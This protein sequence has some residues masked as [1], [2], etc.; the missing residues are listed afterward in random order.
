MRLLVG[1]LMLLQL[2]PT[3]QWSTWDS[4]SC[5]EWGTLEGGSL[6]VYQGS[7]PSRNL[8]LMVLLLPVNPVC[9]VM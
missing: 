1:V 9:A 3:T 7:M 8:G 4:T 5:G 6:E 2:S